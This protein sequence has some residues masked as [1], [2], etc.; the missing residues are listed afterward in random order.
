[1]R[2]EDLSV[3]QTKALLD[4]IRELI[5]NPPDGELDDAALLALL[6]GRVTEADTDPAPGPAPGPDPDPAPETTP[7]GVFQ[8]SVPV[9]GWGAESYRLHWGDESVEIAQSRSDRASLADIETALESL[10]GIRDVEVTAPG[11]AEII[12]GT[13]GRPYRVAIIDADPDTFRVTK[14]NGKTA[15]VRVVDEDDEPAPVDP[16]GVAPGPGPGASTGP[17]TKVFEYGPAGH[18]QALF[19]WV[20]PTGLYPIPVDFD[21]TPY[22]TRAIEL[23]YLHYTGRTHPNGQAERWYEFHANAPGLLEA[24][25]ESLPNVASAEVTIIEGRRLPNGRPTSSYDDEEWKLRI[26]LTEGPG[27]IELLHVGEGPLNPDGR[28]LDVIGGA[29]LYP[30]SLAGAQFQFDAVTSG[31][32]TPGVSEMDGADDAGADPV[33]SV[34]AVDAWPLAVPFADPGGLDLLV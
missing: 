4:A 1:M 10:H 33:A 28:T 14:G 9:S 32:L 2:Y 6:P 24:A 7:Q 16:G 13:G 20:Y 30:L 3:E 17:T 11:L 31:A 25:L 21:F 27:G 22:T 26:E 18:N 15:S 34:P 19:V 12:E 29:N 5:R 8:F 23:S